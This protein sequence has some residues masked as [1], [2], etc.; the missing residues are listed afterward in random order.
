MDIPK[1]KQKEPLLTRVEVSKKNLVKTGML[2]RM[3]GLFGH[4]TLVLLMIGLKTAT[5]S[6]LA[7]MTMLAN[8]LLFS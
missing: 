6:G 4:T 3:L 2:L 5:L 1:S 7:N 8:L